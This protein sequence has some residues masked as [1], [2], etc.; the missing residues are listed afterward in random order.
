MIVFLKH[1]PIEGP[2]TIGL[3]FEKTPYKIKIFELDQGDPLPETLEGIEAVVVLGGPMNVYEE[4]KYPFLKE[5]DEFLKRAL[6]Q[7]IPLLGICLGSQML[8]KVNGARVEKA[9]QE[10]IGWSEIHLTRDGRCDPLFEGL[11]EKLAVFQWHED[12]FSV[13][14]GGQL[15]ATSEVCHN[16][17]IKVGENA[18]GLQFHVEVTQDI[19]ESWIKQY[20]NVSDARK[21]DKGKAILDQYERVKVSFEQQAERLYKNFLEIIERSKATRNVKPACQI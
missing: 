10:E 1:I 15:L 7:S 14:V 12:T 8:A 13:P 3:F 11:D 5:E 4:E 17:A 9:R 6:R 19:I 20:F 21:S 18:Y 2:G 16:Q